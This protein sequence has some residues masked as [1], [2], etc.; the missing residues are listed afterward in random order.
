MFFINA[1]LAAASGKQKN[2]RRFQ[3]WVGKSQF[4]FLLPDEPPVAERA[5]DGRAL[6]PR[7]ANRGYRKYGSFG[8]VSHRKEF[9]VWNRRIVKAFRMSLR[10]AIVA[11]SSSISS[12]APGT[13]IVIDH[14][15]HSPVREDWA[16]IDEAHQGPLGNT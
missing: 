3:R 8:D 13:P 12:G 1:F 7:V 10:G 15:N 6:L 11:A 14:W 5:L 2:H 16:R 9:M 4:W